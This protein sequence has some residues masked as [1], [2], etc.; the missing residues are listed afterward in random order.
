MKEI[1]TLTVNPALD[2]SAT[3]DELRPFS[4]LRCNGEQRDAG[5]GGINVARV[6]TRLGAEPLAIVPAGGPIGRYLA[7]IV[8]AEG[9]R[10]LVVP[11]EGN[12]REDFTVTESASSRQFRF[13]LPG[14][15]LAQTEWE[16][17]LSECAAR[18]HEGTLL[19]ASGS[20]APG[21]PDDFYGRLAVIAKDRGAQLLL[22]SS[23]P[24]L[25]KALAQGVY[26]VKP[27]LREL[28]GLT[29]EP[30]PDRNAWLA[31]S[32]RIVASGGAEVV[33]LSLAERGA[34]FVTR[35]L[36]LHAKAPVVEPRSTVGTGDSF[37]GAL[38]AKLADGCDR[39]EAFRAA[40]A[41]GTAAMLAPGTGLG[42]K[43][44]IDRLMASVVLEEA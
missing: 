28:R 37:L 42:R 31:A 24:A 20:L 26:L 29:G 12:T 11:I 14:P 7:E 21:L 25:E 16:R 9:V 39:R 44:D 23:G 15:R 34:L 19:A 4:K 41:A 5:G 18:L 38:I 43:A 22:D 35:D 40:V 36:A 3:V 2:L 6:A 13:V 27:N 1:V 32:R 33:A 8:K 17:V 10:C 30:L